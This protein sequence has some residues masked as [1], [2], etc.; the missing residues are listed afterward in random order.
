MR[1][2]ARFRSWSL[3]ARAVLAAAAEEVLLGSGTRLRLRPDSAIFH[4]WPDGALGAPL[5]R[6]VGG[7][8]VFVIE[9]ITGLLRSVASDGVG[10][11][12]DL[13]AEPEVG[14]MYRAVVVLANDVLALTRH[15]RYGREANWG[16]VAMPKALYYPWIDIEDEAWLKSSLLYWDEIQTIVPDSMETPYSTEVG[17]ALESEGYLI[18]LRV[19][20]G[21]DEVD[22][23]ADV[24]LDHLTSPEGAQFLLA[25][26]AGR[27]T[28]IHAESLSPRLG[29]LADIHPE[30]M[31]SK[32][33]RALRELGMGTPDGEWMRVN[34]GFADF[35][36]TLLA[37]RLA[38]R[39]G[40]GLVTPL[41][42]ADR[43]A[44][45]ARLDGQA[46]GM[47]RGRRRRMPRELAPGMLGHLALE[48]VN[49][50]PATPVD[51]LLNFRERHSDELGRFRAK[52]EELAASVS[53]DLPEE[54]L[55]QRVHDLHANEVAPATSDLRAALKG[56][57]IKHSTTGLLKVSFL[58]AGTSSLLM[59]A[60]MGTPAALLALAGL[61]LVAA[62][63]MYNV[64]KREL[65][66]QNP[67]SY[68][69]SAQAELA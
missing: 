44:V 20:P 17:A 13:V 7:E 50:D 14:G 11:F 9:R 51:R 43:L 52:I 68:L 27:V 58:S 45:A 25:D 10:H 64:E 29:R 26:E 41:P 55:R 69:L 57:D 31:P 6:S 12:C 47:V 48:R 8:R 38:E 49:V 1:T 60:G 18:P 36:M 33:R 30:K 66:R 53:L 24:V 65:L 34:R 54:A 46:A 62:G 23:L 21:T 5:T 4:P 63:A 28:S 32:I 3:G 35:Y 59:V 67:F 2:H 15:R 22:E 61:S 40:A 42:A 56:L 37:S 39:T 19:N 16:D